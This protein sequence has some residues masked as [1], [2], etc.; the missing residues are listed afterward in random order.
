MVAE[1]EIADRMIQHRDS[2]AVQETRRLLDRFRS[3]NPSQHGLF[4]GIVW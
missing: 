1:T 4:V 2:D 3:G